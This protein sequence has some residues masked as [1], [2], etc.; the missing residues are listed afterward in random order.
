[1]EQVFINLLLNAAQAIEGVGTVRVR[2]LLKGGLV[3]VEI[4][5]TGKGISPENLNKIFDPFFTTKPVGKGTGLGL[6]VSY[7]IVK[8]HRGDIVVESEP[9]R[10]TKFTIFLPLKA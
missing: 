10:G 6:S 5:D 8:Q 1:L 3:C 2:T 9:G 4:M 7:D